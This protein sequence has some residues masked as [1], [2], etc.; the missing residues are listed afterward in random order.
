[1]GMHN[2]MY[3]SI[4]PNNSDVYHYPILNNIIEV[5]RWNIFI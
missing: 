1:M 3:Y 2:N 4:D 5:E